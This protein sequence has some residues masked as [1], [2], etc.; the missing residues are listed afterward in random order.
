VRAFSLLGEERALRA[1]LKL[2]RDAEAGVRKAAVE[3]VAD[4]G[5]SSVIPRLKRLQDDPEPE[6]R[7]AVESA[8]ERLSKRKPPKEERG[9]SP[10]EPP[11]PK[12]PE[13]RPTPPAPEPPP[14]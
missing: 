3:A 11:P 4:A 10:A 14:W 13:G 7:E 2:T 5:D 12:P 1:L 9:T 6:V 8:I